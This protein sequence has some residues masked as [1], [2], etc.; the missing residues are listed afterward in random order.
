LAWLTLLPVITPL[1]ESTQ[2]LAI[3][4]PLSRHNE[5]AGLGARRLGRH[6]GPEG[7][8]RQGRKDRTRFP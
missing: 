8:A 3:E 6:V 1:P 7:T 5:K 2:R 4:D